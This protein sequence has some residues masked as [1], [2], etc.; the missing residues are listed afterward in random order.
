MS[1]RLMIVEDEALEAQALKTIISK[2]FPG[3]D[4]VGHAVSGQEAIMIAKDKVPEIILMDIGIPEIDGLTAQREIIS[5][6]PNVQTIV[7]TA[8]SD[9]H[10]AQSA[11][12]SGVVEYLLKP[13]RKEI[14]VAAIGKVMYGLEQDSSSNITVDLQVT[15]TDE[16]INKAISFIK[17]NYMSDIQVNQLAKLLFLNPQYFSRLFKKEMNISFSEFLILYRIDKAKR[18]LTTTDLPIYSIAAQT[19]FTDASYFCKKFNQY[20][21]K[22]PLNYR[23][24]TKKVPS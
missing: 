3:I 7:L 12:S 8:Y 23:R 21:G 1:Q 22:T 2:E 5:F 24:T 13:A 15:S 10:H 20:V 14:I 16:R 11:I 17:N 4:I 6:L 19:G 9:F 18:L